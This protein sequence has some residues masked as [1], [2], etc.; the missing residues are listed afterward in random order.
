MKIMSLIKKTISDDLK[1]SINLVNFQNIKVVSFP[2][3]GLVYKE[4]I[5]LLC[6]YWIWSHEYPIWFFLP[7]VLLQ[8]LFSFLWGKT[9]DKREKI[10]RK[11]NR[12]QIIAFGIFL[13]SI[14]LILSMFNIPKWV[15]IILLSLIDT[16]SNARSTLATRKLIG[17]NHSYHEKSLFLNKL[18]W[19]RIFICW[20]FFSVINQKPKTILI[21]IACLL[22]LAYYFYPKKELSET[23]HN[24]SKNQQKIH[25]QSV[26]KRSAHLKLLSFA[27]FELIFFLFWSFTENIHAP[28][29]Y[30]QFLACLKTR[31]LMKFRSLVKGQA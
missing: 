14:V 3:L 28:V 18:S 4:I 10:S 25:R 2:I 6:F 27:A 26:N 7:F 20:A 16:Q 13:L 31:Q 30:L 15:I 17:K 29:I 8:G 21:S 12:Y 22:I 11:E 1:S 19:T 24:F 23:E 5:N 9:G